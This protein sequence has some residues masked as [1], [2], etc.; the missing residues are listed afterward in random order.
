MWCTGVSEGILNAAVNN[1]SFDDAWDTIAK[2]EPFL[3]E[4]GTV[5][6]PLH[7]VICPLDLLGGGH[8]QCDQEQMN[9]RPDHYTAA[10]MPAWRMWRHVGLASSGPW[11]A[12]CLIR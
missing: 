6:H 2:M 8:R 3:N 4:S 10:W 1:G 12:V 9:V 5:N 7:I 11:A